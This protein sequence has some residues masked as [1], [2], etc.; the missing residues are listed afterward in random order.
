MMTSC[1]CKIGIGNLCKNR[2]WLLSSDEKSSIAVLQY[3]FYP[4][5]E[6]RNGMTHLEK[7]RGLD[8]DAPMLLLSVSCPFPNPTMQNLPCSSL[9]SIIFSVHISLGSLSR[10]SSLLEIVIVEGKEEEGGVGG[11]GVGGRE[12]EEDDEKE[13]EGRGRR[14]VGGRGGGKGEWCSSYHIFPSFCHL[15]KCLYLHITKC[16]YV[17]RFDITLK[18]IIKHHLPDQHQ[19]CNSTF[20]IKGKKADNL[21]ICLPIHNLSHYSQN[22]P[23]SVP[24]ENLTLRFK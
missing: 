8:H 14:G 16:K 9:P 13:E 6:V 15:L 4:S 19:I 20:N 11:G 1:P 22:N 24:E 17:L 10:I 18:N 2:I 3:K 12:G 21:K 5:E 23:R 7:G